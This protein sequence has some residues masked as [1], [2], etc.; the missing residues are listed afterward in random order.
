MWKATRRTLGA[1]VAEE[2]EMLVSW[3]AGPHQRGSAVRPA[4]AGKPGP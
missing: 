1:R 4:G 3:R 2:G